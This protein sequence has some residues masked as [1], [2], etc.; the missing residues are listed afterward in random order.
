MA[1]NRV[2]SLDTNIILRIIL[3]D[4]PEQFEQ[5]LALMEQEGVTYILSDIALSEAVFVLTRMLVDRETIVA[6][7]TRIVSRP[8]VKVSD[9][10]G[11]ELFSMYL[12]S[13]R[14]S[15]EDCYLTIEAALNQAEPL[16]TF[17]KALAKE[18]RTAKLLG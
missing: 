9:V 10:I 16:W 7:L 14:L 2:E 18:S 12:N 1:S 6:V 17:D 11:L 13:P 5:A 3:Q 8:N 4:V 15:F